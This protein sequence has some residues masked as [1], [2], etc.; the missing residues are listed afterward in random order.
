VRRRA[1]WHGVS[2]LR[3][4]SLEMTVV[5]ARQSLALP[6]PRRTRIELKR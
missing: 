6:S 5:A 1:V 4:A 3:F 2:R